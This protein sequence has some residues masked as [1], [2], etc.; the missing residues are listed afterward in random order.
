MALSSV[1]T[2]DSVTI[3]NEMM[4]GNTITFFAVFNVALDNFHVAG[5]VLDLLAD[6][7]ILL[8]LVY[9]VVM[10]DVIVVF[11]DVLLVGANDVSVKVSTIVVSAIEEGPTPTTIDV[12]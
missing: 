2:K 1:V 11:G 5:S 8:D 7:L 6:C 4:V 12:D 3:T 10:V 9:K